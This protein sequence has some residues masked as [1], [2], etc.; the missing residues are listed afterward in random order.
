MTEKYWQLD[1]QHIEELRESL[2]SVFINEDSLKQMLRIKLNTRWDEI[3]S[4]KTY[5]DRIFN[6]IELWAGSEGKVKQLVLATAYDGSDNIKIQKFVENHIENL[7]EFDADLLSKDALVQ[8]ITIL[9][10]SNS[11]VQILDIGKNMLPER[12]ALDRSRAVEYLNSPELSNWFKCLTLLKLLVEDYLLVEQRSSVFTFVNHLSRLA[13]LDDKTKQDLNK[14]LDKFASN[15]SCLLGQ[16]TESSSTPS[17]SPSGGLQAYLMILVNPEKANKLRAAASLLCIA[18]TGIKKEIPVHLNPEYKERGVL[19]TWKKLS[20]IVAGFIQQSTS[21]ELEH[22][23]NRLGCAYYELTI[24]LF[25]PIGYLCEPIDRWEI[26]DDFDNLVSLGSKYRLVIRS[27]DRVIRPVLRNAFSKAWYRTKDW[28]SQSSES[29]VLD[30]K[31]HHL[32]EIDCVHLEALKEA[33]K[34]KIGIKIT[35]PLPE[36]EPEMLKFLQAMLESGVPLGMWMRRYE[37]LRPNLEAEIAQFWTLELIHNPGK[38]LEKV[39]SVR[40]F[41]FDEREAPKQHWGGH[42]TVLWDD[43]ERMPI[44]EPLQTGG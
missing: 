8:L 23:E 4:G 26:K 2:K 41:A 14:W 24:E 15:S 32:T 37:Q 9:K 6:L 5:N 39:R 34:E 12:V 21:I 40:A 38:F 1:G 36:S 13:S 33:L 29:V 44:V 17:Q 31:I 16:L 7:L 35:C 27:Y 18:P 42:L 11:F 25:L 3:K 10:Q 19:T 43:L 28:L 30:S 20:Q 22:P